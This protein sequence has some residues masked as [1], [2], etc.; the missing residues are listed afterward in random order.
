M[1][2]AAPTL[3]VRQ[4]TPALEVRQDRPT[5]AGTILTTVQTLET[6]VNANIDIINTAVQQLRGSVEAALIIEIRA[7][8]K[9][10]FQAIAAALQQATST[11]ISVTINAVG[12]ITASA[13][14]LTVEQIN[15]LIE[16][17]NV[18]KRV[19]NR[20]QVVITV[21]IKDLSPDILAF[22]NAEVNAVKGVLTPFLQPLVTFLAAVRG[23][24]ASLQVVITGLTPALNDLTGL[25]QNV[26]SS[27][28]L[29]GIIVPA[30]T[31]LSGLLSVSGIS[32][33]LSSLTNGGK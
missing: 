3:E 8:I 21:T 2:L 1:A 13:Q 10:S 15:Q 20:I 12:G 9:A 5:V 28:G 23:F 27:L 18:V 11:I 17:I 30:V 33:T 14:G 22:I 24:N 6:T 16:A 29:Q 26:L 31:G 4:D 19:I 32:S 25:V 7:R